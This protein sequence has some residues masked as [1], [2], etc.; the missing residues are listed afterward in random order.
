MMKLFFLN[1]IIKNLMLLNLHK[2]QK[3][4]LGEAQILINSNKT[5][6]LQQ[7]NSKMMHRQLFNS[8]FSNIQEELLLVNMCQKPLIITETIQIPIKLAH[9]KPLTILEEVKILDSSNKIVTITKRVNI[10]MTIEVDSRLGL[11]ELEVVAAE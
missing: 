7:T 2:K 5:I 8:Q 9:N 1:R 6:T 4:V 10:T 3:K 11:V